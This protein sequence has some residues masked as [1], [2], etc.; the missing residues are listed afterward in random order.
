[1]I[2]IPAAPLTHGCAPVTVHGGGVRLGQH[3]QRGWIVI[4]GGG[5]GRLQGLAIPSSEHTEQMAAGA[6]FCKALSL[7]GLLFCAQALHSA[8]PRGEQPLWGQKSWAIGRCTSCAMC[9]G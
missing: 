8:V 1:M 2:L 6:R 5:W 3:R 7:F 9:V 4:W